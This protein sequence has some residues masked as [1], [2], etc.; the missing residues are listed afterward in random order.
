[1][2]GGGRSERRQ[3]SSSL[4]VQLLIL[5]DKDDPWSYQGFLK[6][7]EELVDTE[8]GRLLLN[9]KLGVTS[10]AIG[11]DPAVVPAATGERNAASMCVRECACTRVQVR[12]RVYGHKHLSRLS[13]EY[14][15]PHHSLECVLLLEFDLLISSQ[16]HT[17]APSPSVPLPLP[18]DG[19]ICVGGS[20]AGDPCAGNVSSLTAEALELLC[21]GGGA[22]VQSGG[23]RGGIAASWSFGAILGAFVVVGMSLIALGMKISADHRR[24]KR[25]RQASAKDQ[26]QQRQKHQERTHGESELR[27]EDDLE[28]AG[29]GAPL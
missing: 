17:T 26:A 29:P 4:L 25:A 18:Q 11:T 7:L 16:P 12:V 2:R 27:D 20:R 24:K 14:A 8:Q 9:G 10:L 15:T 13:W 5:S 1:M 3:G 28:E 23:V 19:F 22:C 21:P 6:S